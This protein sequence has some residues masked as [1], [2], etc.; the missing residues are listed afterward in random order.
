MF[1]EAN[2]KQRGSITARASIE[3]DVKAGEDAYVI[4]TALEIVVEGVVEKSLEK[5]LKEFGYIGS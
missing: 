3:S 2:G 1:L 4:L 5:K